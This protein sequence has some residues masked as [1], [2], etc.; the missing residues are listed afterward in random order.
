MD[1]LGG[2]CIVFVESAAQAKRLLTHPVLDRKARA[3]H[4][5]ATM[6]ERYMVLTAFANREFDVLVATD[7]VSRGVDFDDVR[8]VLQLHPPSNAAQYLHRAGRTGRAGKSGVCITLY[9]ASEGTL[10]RR[11]RENTRQKFLAEAPPA[12]EDV[13]HNA[14]NRLLD[15]LLTVQPEEFQPAMATAERLL[16]EQG[17]RVL[18]TAMAVLDGRHAD[19]NRASREA[20]SFLS[21]RRGFVCFSAHDPEHN[22]VES[23]E[24]LR[25]II[26]SLLPKRAGD[27]AVGRVAQTRDGWAVDVASRWATLLAD[28]LKSGRR[29]SPFELM[30]ARKAPRLLRRSISRRA[31]RLPW[32]SM[33]KSAFKRRSSGGELLDHRGP[34]HDGRWPGAS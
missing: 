34:R 32:A 20:P 17:P 15:T 16:E 29:T 14:M 21:G 19:L 11:V 23:M 18:A 3:I 1:E 30:V 25:R 24:T 13:H 10:V 33:R 22:I 4:S 9:D 26:L 7:L 12:P 31:R 6:E 28:D 8:L 5:E 27:Q 2:K